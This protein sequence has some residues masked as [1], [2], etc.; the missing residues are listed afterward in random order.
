[1][2]KQFI[3]TS[4]AWVALLVLGSE[5]AT[6]AAPAPFGDPQP[7]SAAI[8]IKG[9]VTDESGETLIGATV[10]VKGTNAGTVTDV[11]G[12]YELE[13]AGKDAILVFS[14]TGYTDLEIVVGEQTTINVVM[15]SGVQLDEIVVVGYGVQKKSDVTGSVTSVPK[16][17]LSEL[18]V[19]NVLQSVQGAVAGVN[20]T[21]GSSVPG[22]GNS[23]LVRGVNS[24]SASTGPFIVLD[25][26]P[27]STTGGSI[28]DI[29]PNDI[30]SIEIL[31][32][33]S[34]VA[35]YGTRGANGVILI[36]T[37]KG[38]SGKPVIK[39]NT[40]A[41][42][43]NFANTVQPMGPDEYVQKYADWKVQ[44]GSAD[45]NPLPNASEQAN[46]AAGNSTDWLDQVSQNGNIQNHNLSISGGGDNVRYY[47]SGD[48]L[49]QNGVVKGYQFN[50]ASLRSNIDA[51]ITDFLDAGLNVFLTS[52]NYDGGRADLR[53]AGQVSPYGDLRSANGN[54]AIYPM[55]P[56]LLYLNP[57]LGTLTTRNE[58]SQNVNTNAFLTFKPGFLPGF[59]YKINGAYSYVPTQFQ[60][61]IGRSAGDQLGTAK[62][63]NSETKN[64]IVENIFTYAKDFGAHNIGLT[65][66]YSAQKTNFFSSETN[67]SGFINDVLEFN[68]LG[69]AASVS[70]LS[71]SYKS[72][73]LSQML[74]VNYSYDSRYLLTVTARRDGYSAF[75]GNTSKYG[76]FPS[77]ALG[78]NIG[79]ES[80]MA[81]SSAISGLKFRVS[82][83]LSGNQAIEPNATLSTSSTVRLPFN[84]I[85]TVGV[86]GSVLG[87][88]DLTW[89]STR[90]TNVGID[91]DLYRGKIAGS[92][93]AYA[94]KTEDLLLFRAI[95]EI[96][97]FNRVLDNLGVVKN[98][99]VELTLNTKNYTKG[100]FRW[101]SGL[102]FSA[103]KNE[104][105]DLYGD[106]K[107]DIGNRWFIGQPVNVVYDYNQTG[108]WQT[109]EDASSQDP[110][111]KP[112]DIKF[113]DTNGDGAITPADRVVLG[114][115]NPKWMGGLTNTFHYN[116]FHLTIFIQTVQG[117]TK[118]NPLVDYRDLAG[119]E[120]LPGGLGYWT[121]QNGNNDRPSLS[122]INARLYNYPEDASFTRLKDVTLSWVASESVLGKIGLGGLTIYASGRNLATWT[123]WYGWD[124]ELNFNR[125]LGANQ[126]NY[127]LVK[128]FIVGANV[129]LK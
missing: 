52:N 127:P 78:W 119:R 122:F 57:L 15:K 46:L 81:G 25:G 42:T 10:Q 105:V 34:A 8:L 88:P 44:A 77:V 32:D 106:K 12:S 61:Y 129:T 48:Y 35:I 92:V 26:M 101:E 113:A 30:E 36:T 111:A 76:V 38:K 39:L 41:G 103:N 29:N 73:L 99:G 69:T 45:Q 50:R 55:A 71:D 80:F 109:A 24:I 95:P 5:P 112:G 107:D 3:L 17:R 65:G 83:G 2:M 58:R 33:A 22:S 49:K 118:N 93:E 7:T 60:S 20:I 82:Y 123:K 43:E 53:L 9:V 110:T 37:K 64:W 1:M 62:V 125:D 102:N 100:G 6:A 96:T 59:S 89:E 97:G 115:V 18:P 28:N 85:S 114:Q 27:F 74:R 4:L 51:T 11:D 68:N 63:A 124:P 14:Y 16:Q 75:G 66:L 108:I 56:E 116:S 84:G 117:I 70:G 31:K 121:A 86:L 13:V 79:N 90:G 94:T 19:T 47:I 126:N 104:I 67:A 128:T 23:A 91:F 54:L 72:T 120:N 98:R 40:Y 21:Q 87:N